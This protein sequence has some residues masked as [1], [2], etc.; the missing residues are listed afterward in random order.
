MLCEPPEFVTFLVTNFYLEYRDCHSPFNQ[1][2]C[3]LHLISPYNDT[4]GSNI[5]VMRIKDM[6]TN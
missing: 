5:K 2:E 4:I 6:I 3:D 1:Q